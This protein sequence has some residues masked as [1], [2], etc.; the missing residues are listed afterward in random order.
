MPEFGRKKAIQILQN[1]PE[2][3]QNSPEKRQNT[4]VFL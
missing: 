2:N 1:S 3:L 4:A